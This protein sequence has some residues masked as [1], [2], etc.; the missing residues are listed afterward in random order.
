MGRSAEALE[1]AN[2]E[3]VEVF[4]VLAPAIIYHVLG[5]RAEADQAL[6]EMT[7]EHADGFA[8]FIAEVH[9]VRGESDEAFA[10]LDRAYAEKDNGLSLSKSS[11]RLRPLHGD[12]R[13][14][15]FMNKM[16]FEE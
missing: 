13:W 11:P 15:A 5:Q 1:E 4:R 7:D 8:F 2:R 9:G 14:R 3:P 12:P 6:R 16:G 10:C